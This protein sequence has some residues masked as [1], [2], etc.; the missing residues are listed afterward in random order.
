MFLFFDNSFE[1]IYFIIRDEDIP[2]IFKMH[3]IEVYFSFWDND[4]YYL[5]R[6]NDI[7][8]EEKV[9]VKS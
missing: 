2:I 5:L 4:T 8:N 7:K 6:R 9:S 3:K 1:E